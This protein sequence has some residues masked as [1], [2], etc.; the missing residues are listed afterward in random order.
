M[1]SYLRDHFQGRLPFGRSFWINFVTLAVILDLAGTI[2]HEAVSDAPRAAFPIGL[3]WFLGVNV[4]VYAWQVCG[5]WRASE[6]ALINYANS[7]WIRAAQAVV[8]VSFLVVFTRALE[9]VHLAHVHYVPP[10]ERD[11]VDDPAYV[12]ELSA[13]G[14]MVKLSGDID[15]GITQ[16]LTTLLEHRDSIRVVHLES[17]GGL[18][19]EGR[20]LAKLIARFGLATYSRDGCS[21]ACTLAYVSGTERY[22]GPRARLGFHGY[23]LNSPYLPLFMN[24][25]EEMRKDLAFFQSRGIEPAFLERVFNTP[26]S[27][28]WFPSYEELLEAGVVH[29]INHLP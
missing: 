24:P 17:G 4:L 9:V 22:L 6:Q 3:L 29:A 5:V 25:A 11:R 20:G 10:P 14:S 21:S 8:L 23:Q 18:V 27:D 7:L 26:G 15:F 2:L 28:M 16:D 19:S 13:D 12:L 1:F